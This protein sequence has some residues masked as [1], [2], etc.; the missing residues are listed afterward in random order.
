MTCEPGCLPWVNYSKGYV[1]PYQTLNKSVVSPVF[2]VNSAGLLT[3]CFPVEMP[4]RIGKDEMIKLLKNTA[5]TRQFVQDQNGNVTVFSVL[6]ILLVLTVSGA[7]VDIMRFEATRATLQ[8][9]LDRAVLAAADLD[10]DQDPHDVVVDYLTKVGVEK[11]LSGITVDQGMNY[12]TVT[13]WGEADLS[14]YFLRMSGIDTLTPPALS[15]AEEKISNVEISLVLDVSGSMGS[16][17][18]IVNLRTAAKQFVDTVVQPYEEGSGLTTVSIVPYNATVNLGPMLSSRYNL[19]DLHDYSHC[20][21]FPD[22]AFTQIAISTTAEL[23]RLAHF[24]LY[25]S[26]ESSTSLSRPWCATGTDSEVIVHSA[27]TQRLNA[28]IDSLGADGNTAIDLGMKW[29][30]ALLDPSAK[31]VVASLV[32][33]G[34][35]IAPAATRPAHY[36]DPEAIKFIVVMTDGANTTEYDLKPQYKYGMSNV[37]VDERST[38]SLSDDRYSLLVDDNYGSNNDVYFRQR[39]ENSSWSYRYQNTPDGG[40]N[41]RRLSN[42]ELFARFGTKA[43]AKKMYERPYYDGYVSYN[44]YYDVYYGYTAIVGSTSAD[45]RLADICRT[46]KEAGIVIFSVAFEAPAAGQAALADC[47]SSAAHYFD[48]EGV[49]IAETFH[50][51]ARQINSLRLIQ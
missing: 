17:S 51:I 16:N 10:Q 14:T 24:D 47:A 18:R 30:A 45:A 4:L 15:V 36:D 28:H 8:T 40:G 49:E 23:E 19:S 46:A 22:T 3:I 41:A 33:A 29:G 39:Y 12:R 26:N 7:A 21:I 5:C 27:D 31:P 50:S 43:V 6:M 44:S 9:T 38:S 25:S 34:G 48:V 37:W 20:A 1:N 35:V 2:A 32:G 11:V 42:A 13:A